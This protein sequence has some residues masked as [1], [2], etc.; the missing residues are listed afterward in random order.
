MVS[1]IAIS[2]VLS[3]S[4]AIRIAMGSSIAIS[5]AMSSSIAISIGTDTSIAI[6]IGNATRIA[7]LT[8][9]IVPNS[10]MEQLDNMRVHT[11]SNIIVNTK[12]TKLALIGPFFCM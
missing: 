2:I 10:I 5:I 6:H 7:I 12:D 9:S 8:N 3:S 11:V 4:I 1:S